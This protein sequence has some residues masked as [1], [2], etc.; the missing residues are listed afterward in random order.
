MIAA[1]CRL[2]KDTPVETLPSEQGLKRLYG[3]RD[4]LLPRQPGRNT[5][6]RTRI[7][8]GIVPGL[9]AWLRS[10]G[11]NTSIRTRI[12]TLPATELFANRGS[13]S[14]HFHQNKD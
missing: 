6:I 13:R 7:E 4:R 1:S 5:S 2:R 12:E 14:K 8:T 10:A 11:R 3:R 9:E